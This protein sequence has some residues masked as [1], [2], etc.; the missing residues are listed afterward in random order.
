MLSEIVRGRIFFFSEIVRGRL[1]IF[2]SRYRKVQIKCFFSEIVR[3]R[4]K[5]FFL[6][7]VRGRLKIKI[8]T[9]PIY[10]GVMSP[11]SNTKTVYLS[12]LL[13]RGFNTSRVPNSVLVFNVI[14]IV[15]VDTGNT[16][17]LPP[18]LIFSMSLSAGTSDS[19]LP[20]AMN[21]GFDI[22]SIESQGTSVVAET[23]K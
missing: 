16:K 21:A 5:I 8:L 15:G 14:V 13:L 6:E 4:L 12:T 23:K 7:I 20:G 19:I 2:F 22:P 17:G 1:K 11:V 10:L 3:G 9:S 18:G